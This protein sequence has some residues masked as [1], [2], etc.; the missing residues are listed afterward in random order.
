MPN[1]KSIATKGL[2]GTPTLSGSEVSHRGMTL[3]IVNFETLSFQPP[4]HLAQAPLI[5]SICREL[6]DQDPQ[7]DIEEQFDSIISAADFLVN[8]LKTSHEN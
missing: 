6:L 4:Q 5:N 8:T 2:G 1:A 3:S 7:L